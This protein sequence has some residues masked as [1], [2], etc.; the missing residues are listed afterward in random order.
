MLKLASSRENENLRQHQKLASFASHPA[1]EEGERARGMA[2]AREGKVIAC[3]TKDEL[4]AHIAMAG[5]NKLVRT[6]AAP[7]GRP[8]SFTISVS[9]RNERNQQCELVCGSCLIFDCLIRVR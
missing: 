6:Y 4:D 9:D 3:H 2:T 5:R 8:R 7:A 1:R